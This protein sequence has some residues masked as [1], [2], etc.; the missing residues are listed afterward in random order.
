METT[1][2]ESLNNLTGGMHASV[3]EGGSGSWKLDADEGSSGMQ[4]DSQV[5]AA[6]TGD[7]NGIPAGGSPAGILRTPNAFSDVRACC[8]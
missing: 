4:M 1:I 5:R 7:F 3:S 6:D 2:P 8:C